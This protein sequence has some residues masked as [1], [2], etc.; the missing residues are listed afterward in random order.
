MGAGFVIEVLL[1]RHR[2]YYL[3]LAE[4]LEIQLLKG[5]EQ[6][7]SMDR[8]NKEY[9]TYKHET[10]YFPNCSHFPHNTFFS[11]FPLDQ[12]SI[13]FVLSFS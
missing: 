13:S 9:G 11:N 5:T 6:S 8:F 7:I 10:H 3:K 1:M 2:R 12:F 4:E